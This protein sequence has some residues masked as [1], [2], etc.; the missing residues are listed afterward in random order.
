VTSSS[1]SRPKLQQTEPVHSWCH[2]GIWWLIMMSASYDHHALALSMCRVV[3]TH[4]SVHLCLC[5]RGK[6]KQT[7]V[8]K[9]GQLITT[10][11]GGE[12]SDCTGSTLKSNKNK[13][14]IINNLTT[15][16]YR[17]FNRT[18]S[19]IRWRWFSNLLGFLHRSRLHP[20]LQ[21][22]LIR[23]E[24]LLLQCDKLG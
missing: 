5:D 2:V 11:Y 4:V 9:Y 3:A 7:V 13:K 10:L 20:N 17:I 24:W 8:T 1:S 15:S 18:I 19:V 6:N 21:T 12:S 22:A 16:H 23:K 14:K